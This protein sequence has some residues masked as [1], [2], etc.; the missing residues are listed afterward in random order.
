M[1]A[2]C[3]WV[4]NLFGAQERKL[5]QLLALTATGVT[6]TVLYCGVMLCIAKNDFMDVLGSLRRRKR[7]GSVVSGAEIDKGGNF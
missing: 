1:A 5:M 4:H 7:S 3:I 6:G 2:C